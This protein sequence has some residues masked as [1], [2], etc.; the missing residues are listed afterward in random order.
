M[1][2]KT[3]KRWHFYS[4]FIQQYGTF[5]RINRKINGTKCNP[6][7]NIDVYET[8]KYIL[9]KRSITLF[10]GIKKLSPHLIPILMD[11]KINS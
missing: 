5:V 8:I 9:D 2:I 11:F 1:K 3:N 7:S 10:R 4:I 6:V